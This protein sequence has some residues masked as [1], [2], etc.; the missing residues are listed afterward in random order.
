[1][2]TKITHGKSDARMYRGSADY[3]VFK[4]WKLKNLCNKTAADFSLAPK[5]ILRKQILFIESTLG[6]FNISP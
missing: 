4:Y 6:F 3:Q 5:E 1:M 2:I